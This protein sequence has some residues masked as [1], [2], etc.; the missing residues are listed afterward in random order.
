[1][2]WIC[3]GIVQITRPGLNSSDVVTRRKLLPWF[4]RH[5]SST[6]GSEKTSRTCGSGHLDFTVVFSGLVAEMGEMSWWFQQ[7]CRQGSSFSIPV[8]SISSC[9]PEPT[10]RNIYSKKTQWPHLQPLLPTR[11]LTIRSLFMNILER[12]WFAWKWFTSFS[13]N[14]KSF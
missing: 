1:M 11:L 3:P 9:S 6:V 5:G 7:G 2:A 12:S 13:L 8:N 10:A 14:R 4:G